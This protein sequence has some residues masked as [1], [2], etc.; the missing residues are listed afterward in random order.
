MANQ[1]LPEQILQRIKKT[2]VIDLGSERSLVTRGPKHSDRMFVGQ[3][4][5]GHDGIGRRIGYRIEFE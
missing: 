1:E 3:F 5:P 2:H 4:A